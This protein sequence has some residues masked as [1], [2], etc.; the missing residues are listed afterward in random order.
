MPTTSRPRRARPLV[1]A[2]L[3]GSTLA[4]ATVAAA[5]TA[6][7]PEMLDAITLEL[8]MSDPEWIGNPP[9]DPYWEADSSAIY[10]QQER[11]GS[12]LVDL[13]RQP[14]PTGEAT[15]V[16]DDAHGV[17][18]DP[19]GEWSPDRS[20]KVYLRF[21]DVW[22]HDLAHGKVQITRTS[23][24]ER[25]PLFLL[26][27]RVAY[28]RG[29]GVFAQRLGPAATPGLEEQLVDLRMADDPDAEEA[30][31]G[32]LEE[33]Q[34][35]LFDYLRE[36]RAERRAE[37]ETA[38]ER[39]RR[40]PARPP[41]PWYLGAEHTL[42]QVALSPDGRHLALVVAAA[43]A[44]PGPTDK[45]ASWV[46]ESGY[47]TARDV[48]PKVGTAKG[49]GHELWI[50]D[51]AT[52]SRH[53][54][55][56][57]T[58]P[59]IA[60]DPLAELRAAAEA[61]RETASGDGETGDDESGDEAEDEAEDET[62]DETDDEVAE[63][64]TTEVLDRETGR[65][66]GA[67]VAAAA[68]AE[69]SADGAVADDDDEPPTPRAVEIEEEVRWS[70]DGELL[71]F[72]AHSFD[73]KDRWLA[74]VEPGEADAAPM[75]RPLHRLSDPDGWINWD[76]NG[77]GWLRGGELWFLSEETGWSQLY[78]ADTEDGGIR[79]LT[80]G[81]YLVDEV[82]VPRDERHLYFS[83]NVDHPGRYEIYRV[84][85]ADG[86]I[87]QMT[88]LGGINSAVPSPDGRWLLVT[89]STATHPPELY[90]QPATPRA[91]SRRLTHTVSAEFLALPWVEPEIVEV[92]SSDGPR[93]VY[94]RYYDAGALGA[95]PEDGQA[96]IFI[97][98]AGYLQNAHE[99][100]S[101]YFR[102]FMFHTL[103]VKHGYHVL[104]MDYRGSR[105]YGRDWR[106][107][108]Y[109][110]M[111]TPE[112]QDL[113]DGVAW[114]ISEH[115]VDPERIGTY[116]GSYGGFM[117]LMALFKRPGLFAAGAALR[118]VTDWAHYNH[119]YTSNILNTPEVDPEAYDRSSPIE[120]AAGLED[121]LLIAAPMQ[122]DN[123]FFQDT[124]R[125]AQRL[126]ELE[127]EDW[128]VAIYP[129]E[130]HGFLQPSSWLDEYRRIFE[131]FQR[132]VAGETCP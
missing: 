112:L 74:L 84:G 4:L 8:I 18:G 29:D 51:L 28:R 56:L 60:D 119:P 76:F 24:D 62:D 67:E 43:E 34:L 41:L 16:A 44:D 42:Q 117:V 23:V 26:D 58:L 82:R 55:D 89:H 125:L 13:Y 104:D 36:E 92:P 123:V 91:A 72:F 54:V 50:L 5:Q 103:L 69:P 71:A 10:Y 106:T 7:A 107:A 131:L 88:D 115:R 45:M 49:V 111:G 68:T 33:Q 61:R 46:T 90:L 128:E 101:S 27:G 63:Q 9:E 83:A 94:S 100:W 105:G 47:V 127:K 31:E 21:G 87:E 122:D 65:E 102:E 126:I 64:A 77:F 6:P 52:R 75:L 17:A 32:F 57:A 25:S 85:V 30:P 97:H 53:E 132:H 40:D 98:G 14:I 93:P 19:R 15:Q 59:G 2:I 124:V 22:V 118:P 86:R 114:L 99:G 113:E 96:V 79:R 95:R 110:Q 37:R 48:R 66:A 108:I 70:V 121:P 12:D 1:N 130:P 80:D 35:R 116:G 109:R 38:A 20:R 73:N 129:V 78:L 3:A 11:R 81:D 39:Q 120:F